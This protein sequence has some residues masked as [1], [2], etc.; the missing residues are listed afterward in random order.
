MWPQMMTRTARSAARIPEGDIEV[1][2][3]AQRSAIKLLVPVHDPA[4][5]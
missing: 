5:V 3:Q 4:G 2:V 1:R